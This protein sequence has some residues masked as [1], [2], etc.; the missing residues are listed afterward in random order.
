MV[1][2]GPKRAF[3]V[4]S[5]L[6]GL[7]RGVRVGVHINFAKF[8]GGGGGGGKTSTLPGLM[9]VVK[10]GEWGRGIWNINI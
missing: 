7:M 2:D 1:I 9:V 6:L 10:K 8:D 3:F 4:S 5:T